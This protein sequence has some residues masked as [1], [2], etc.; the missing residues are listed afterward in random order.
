MSQLIVGFEYVEKSLDHTY[1]HNT[2]VKNIK[3]GEGSKTHINLQ[4]FAMWA[5]PDPKMLLERC[6]FS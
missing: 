1:L 4:K 3:H 2:G 6:G 5:V